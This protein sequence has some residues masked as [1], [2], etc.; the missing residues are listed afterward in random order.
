MIS[1]YG[2]LA[3]LRERKRSWA[4][5]MVSLNYIISTI[6]APKRKETER[7][8]LFKQPQTFNL[9]LTRT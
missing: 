7:M 2:N 9:F 1:Q 4:P 5:K 8:R 6:L 3:R